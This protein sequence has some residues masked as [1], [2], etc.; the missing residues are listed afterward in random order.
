M[1]LT[2]SL[3]DIRERGVDGRIVNMIIKKKMQSPI[4]L[5][6]RALHGGFLFDLLRRFESL[7][8]VDF[9]LHFCDRN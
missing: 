2:P 4:S 7:Q 6:D 9:S 8:N 1:G 3:L 5:G